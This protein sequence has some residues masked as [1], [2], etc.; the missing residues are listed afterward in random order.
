MSTTFYGVVKRGREF[1]ASHSPAFGGDY[2]A[3]LQQRICFSKEL[4]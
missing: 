2:T 1:H 4:V 3:L